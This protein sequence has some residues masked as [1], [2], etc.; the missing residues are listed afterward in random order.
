MV[1]EVMVLVEI[2]LFMVILKDHQLLVDMVDLV[3]RMGI[4][5]VISQILMGQSLVVGLVGEEV[6]M[7]MVDRMLILLVVLFVYCGVVVDLFLIMLM[8]KFLQHQL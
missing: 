2:V 1:K 5:M 8:I 6:L 4:I 7:E 3:D